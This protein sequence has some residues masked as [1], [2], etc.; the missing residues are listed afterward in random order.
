MTQEEHAG[1]HSQ[2]GACGSPAG[3]DGVGGYFSARGEVHA[4]TVRPRESGGIH[5]NA[6]GKFTA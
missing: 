6:V 1:R 3:S 2:A 5:R 4:D